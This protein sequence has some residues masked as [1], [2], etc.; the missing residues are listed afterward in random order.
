MFSSKQSVVLA[1]AAALVACACA[2]PD[3][4][5]N[6]IQL[7]QKLSVD[8]KGAKQPIDT[9]AVNERYPHAVLFGGTC[10][11]TI[12]S[13][14]WILTAGHC[15][16]F[17]DG[18]GVLA[19][20]NNSD[21]SGVYRF[22]KRLI[23]HPLFSVGPYWLNAEEFNLKQ[24]A[25]RWDF[26]LAELEEPLPLDGKIMAAAKLD[27]QPDLSA[28][29]DVGYAGYGTD[30]HGGT[31]RSEMHAME[32]SVQSNEVCSKLEQFEA[33]DML[34]AKGRPPRY[35]SACNGDSGSGLVD[36]NGR[37]VGVASWVENDA[38]E[39]RNGNLVV[40]SR[41]SSVREWIRQVTNI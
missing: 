20:T 25:A 31:M 34:C 14:T 28:G 24:V 38:F 1:V 29:L 15:T 13:P 2:A 22:T 41:V 4:G 40:F 16:L 7:N 26:L 36:N 30:H 27:D 5:A 12:I 32:L 35:D 19:G 39:C 8:A 6:D 3:P 17:N 37:L 18:R 11:G 21:V 33:K 10:G 23:I 9:R